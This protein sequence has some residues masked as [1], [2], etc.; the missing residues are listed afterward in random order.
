[1]STKHL[2][3]D[4]LCPYKSLI[5]TEIRA[6]VQL[7]FSAALVPLAPSTAT[8]PPSLASGELSR[9]RQRYTKAGSGGLANRV[10]NDLARLLC[11]EDGRHKMLTNVAP[12]ATTTPGVEAGFL[13]YRETAPVAWTTRSDVTDT[14]NHMAIVIRLGSGL[15]IG[16]SDS[17]KRDLAC[18]HLSD[19]D[20][21][22]LRDLKP[23]PPGRLN[24]AFVHGKTLQLW[25]A[26][27]ER[28]SKT[29]AERKNLSGPD[30]RH[31]LEPH[32]DQAYMFTTARMEQDTTDGG[33]QSIG[34]SPRNSRIWLGPS[35]GWLDFVDS[36]TQ[37]LE[38]VTSTTHSVEAPFPFLAVPADDV[39]L[40]KN[41]FEFAISPPE[42]PGINPPEEWFDEAHYKVCPRIGANLKVVVW[43]RGQCVGDLDLDLDVAPGCKVRFAKIDVVGE[44]SPEL[45]ELQCILQHAPD[46]VKIR[47]DSGHTIINGGVFRVGFREFPFRGFR[48][49]SFAGIDLMKEKPGPNDAPD[50]EQIGKENSLFCWVQRKYKT[51]WLACDDGSG[52]IADFIHIDDTAKPPCITLIHAKGANSNSPDRGIAV[53]AYE[54]VTSQAVKNLRFL[55]NVIAAGKLRERAERS[56]RDFLWYNG[57]RVNGRRSDFLDILDSIGAN[58]RRRV[59]ILQPHVGEAQHTAA[60]SA[61]NTQEHDR[62]RQL[63]ALLLSVNATIQ[64]MSAELEVIGPS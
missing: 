14:L 35:Q 16:L 31:A 38:C 47:Y 41:A 20:Y 60:L 9:T 52:E 42:S 34:V 58:R 53:T 18:R 15:A 46:R 24:A 61:P 21:S 4:D 56:Q 29:K 23:V 7:A 8:A 51:G 33:T 54:I 26:N 45:D 43:L 49:E 39:K 40:V 62:L 32:S 50:L 28:S 37:M 13:H 59:V 22:G 5:L 12:T 19:P 3:F 25:L 2:Q 1:M 55:E 64:D 10:L 30:L 63:D 6:N 27:T 44:S 11:P 57:M 48:W 17:S 36:A